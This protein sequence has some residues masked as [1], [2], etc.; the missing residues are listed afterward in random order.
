[1]YYRDTTEKNAGREYWCGRMSLIPNLAAYQEEFG[2]DICS[3]FDLIPA[4]MS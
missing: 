3:V 4:F 2:S 1:M